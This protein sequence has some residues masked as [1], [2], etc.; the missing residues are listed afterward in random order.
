MPLPDFP[1]VNFPSFFVSTSSQRH[2]VI[3]LITACEKTP[4]IE[5]RWDFLLYVNS[6]LATDFLIFLSI[7]FF[8]SLLSSKLPA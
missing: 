7:F 5:H 1:L 8:T 2:S 6:R 4:S 3:L